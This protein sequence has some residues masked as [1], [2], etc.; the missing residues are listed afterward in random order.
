MPELSAEEFDLR[1]AAL[2]DKIEGLVKEAGFANMGIFPTEDSPGPAFT[3]TVGLAAYGGFE[4][5]MAGL[6]NDG[7]GNMMHMVYSKLKENW[8]PLEE[9]EVDWLA[10]L[11]MR[12]Y[13]MGAEHKCNVARRFWNSRAEG[14]F[15]VYQIV[16]PDSNGVFPDE[17]GFETK[18]IGRQ[19][20]EG[21]PSINNL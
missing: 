9:M 8:R 1:T 7:M 21:S 4:Y 13:L 19:K 10:N 11:P 3:Y 2:M 6:S 12:F 5:L 17:N 20:V 14:G 18:F 15:S 16:W